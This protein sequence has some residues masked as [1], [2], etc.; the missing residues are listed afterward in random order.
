M[1]KKVGRGRNILVIYV[2][3]DWLSDFPWDFPFPG[4]NKGWEEQKHGDASHPALP[5]LSQQKVWPLRLQLA[6]GSLCHCTWL[7]YSAN[8][9]SV[10]VPLW[11]RSHLG[12]KNTVSPKRSSARGTKSSVKIEAIGA[13]D[14]MYNTFDTLE[15]YA[16]M[17][18][19]FYTLDPSPWS[20][21]HNPCW[22][23]LIIIRIYL[24]QSQFVEG[25]TLQYG[26]KRC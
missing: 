6:T 26:S 22:G 12:V 18:G 8:P 2:S 7:L 11:W 1:E 24:K 3:L 9:F 19:K 16:L 20:T 15:L 4:G 23:N 13:L 14:A 10:I 5:P 17:C 25:L 21:I